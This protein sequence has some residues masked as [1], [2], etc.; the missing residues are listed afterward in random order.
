MHRAEAEAKGALLGRHV[1]LERRLLEANRQLTASLEAAE[2]RAEAAEARLRLTTGASSE[3][4][5]TERSETEVAAAEELRHL[6]RELSQASAALAKQQG[7]LQSAQRAAHQAEVRA[8]EAEA[9][10]LLHQHEAIQERDRRLAAEAESHLWQAQASSDTRHSSHAE[11][12]LRNFRGHVAELEEERDALAARLAEL[13]SRAS[14]QKVSPA[15]GPVGDGSE[16]GALQRLHATAQDLEEQLGFLQ[17]QRRQEVA[18]LQSRILQLE[19]E[20]DRA[21]ECN[22]ELS[23]ALEETALELSMVGRKSVYRNVCLFS[24]AALRR[25]MS[26]S[27]RTQFFFLSDLCRSEESAPKML[28]T[29]FW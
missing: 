22:A 24:A 20:L 2:G 12:A 13:S 19:S 23:V 9:T 26:K 5:D 6:Q 7:A 15:Q 27:N 14:L 21:S 16:R 11:E 18:S 3:G 8:A 29:G 17:R 4:H 10:A 28:R 25:G 1:E